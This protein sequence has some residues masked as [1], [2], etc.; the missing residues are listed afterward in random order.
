V[1]AMRQTTSRGWGGFAFASLGV[2]WSLLL[3]VATFTYPWSSTTEGAYFDSP[4]G[5]TGVVSSTRTSTLF[6]ES[7]W[8]AVAAVCV[9][10]LLAMLVWLGLRRRCIRG[11]SWID[12]MV[13]TIVGGL[14]L[15]S[16]IAGFSFGFLLIPLVLLLGAAAALTPEAGQ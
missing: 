7:G 15:M 13:W 5:P 1:T 8:W 12:G 11:A 14:F 9:P 10:L 6:Q 16:F 4:N 3:L 2:G